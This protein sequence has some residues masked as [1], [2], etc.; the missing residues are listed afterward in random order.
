MYRPAKTGVVHRIV[1]IADAI[2]GNSQKQSTTAVNLFTDFQ[3]YETLR[4][5]VY[6]STTEDSIGLNLTV[7][8]N[9][10]VRPLRTTAVL[11]EMIL[12]FDGN[13]RHI[14]KYHYEYTVSCHLSNGGNTGLQTYPVVGWD[15]SNASTLPPYTKATKRWQILPHEATSE[16]TNTFSVS[17][18]LV[19]AGDLDMYAVE[20]VSSVLQPRIYFG[21]RFF[22]TGSST[23]V[24]VGSNIN[25]S[26]E[27]YTEDTK[28]FD[29]NV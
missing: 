17:G 14:D 26:V 19:E 11:C 15:A 7:K 12:P 9:Q 18:H 4:G 3:D 10:Q 5:L 24:F 6:S 27:R 20:N 22:A 1:P 21:V 23:N 2:A 29:P 25:I 8:H 13:N 16:N 28:T